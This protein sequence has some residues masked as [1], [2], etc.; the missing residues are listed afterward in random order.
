MIDLSAAVKHNEQL[1]QDKQSRI[2]S[3]EAELV[4]VRDDLKSVEVHMAELESTNQLLKDEYQA[5]QLALSSAENKL[6]GIQKENEMLVQQ[7]MSLKAKDADRMNLENDMFVKRQ[8]QQMQ[9]ELAEAAK[10]QKSVSPEKM[11]HGDVVGD[12]G[13][14]GVADG[15]EVV[16]SMVQMRFEAHDGE[17]MCTKWDVLGR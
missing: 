9:I 14:A 1:I 15:V 8:Q 2:E 12:D 11:F 7:L 4:G 17:I 3:L 6:R 5:L 16:P 13:G 10:D